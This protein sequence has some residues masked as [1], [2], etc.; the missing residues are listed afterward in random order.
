MIAAVLLA[1]QAAAADLATGTQLYDSGRWADALAALAPLAADGDAEAQFLSGAMLLDGGNGISR[2]RARALTLLTIAA[3][4]GHP[5][6]AFELYLAEPGAP[7]SLAWAEK[8]AAQGRKLDGHRRAQAA[9]CAE[10]L[11]QEHL[12]GFGRPRDLAAA[13]AWL[14]LAVEL[15]RNEAKPAL[16]ELDASLS[17]EERSRAAALAAAIE[18]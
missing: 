7:G 15:G 16:A 5:G 8:L 9:L 12:R 1:G 18:R 11:G 10:A 6:A 3:E 4:H 17:P 13:R 2:D 14:G